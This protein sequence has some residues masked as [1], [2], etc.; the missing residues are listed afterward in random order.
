MAIKNVLKDGEFSLNATDRLAQ[1]R[2]IVGVAC[3]SQNDSKRGPL[4]RRSRPSTQTLQEEAVAT[5]EPAVQ[6][7]GHPRPCGP[8]QNDFPSGSHLH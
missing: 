6:V 5:P 3:L 8:C 2:G 4:A 1:L 7:R